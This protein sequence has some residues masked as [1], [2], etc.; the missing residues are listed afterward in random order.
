MVKRLIMCC[1]GTWNSPDQSTRGK[2][3]PTNVTKLAEAIPR[4]D[5]TAWSNACTTRRGSAPDPGNGSVVEPS[6]S[7]SPATSVVIVPAGR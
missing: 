4:P 7:A 5:P 6:G 3:C 2:P 1:D